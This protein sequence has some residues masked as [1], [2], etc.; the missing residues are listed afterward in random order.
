MLQG[1]LKKREIY[2]CISITILIICMIDPIT[3]GC[4]GLAESK[5]DPLVGFAMK[6]GNPRKQ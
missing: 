6:N 2:V 1:H 3:C 4:K 5:E